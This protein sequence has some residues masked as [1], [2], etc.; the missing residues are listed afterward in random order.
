M[1]G[2]S[3]VGTPAVTKLLDNA[4]ASP[5]F[6]TPALMEPTASLKDGG[7][8]ASAPEQGC[9]LSSAPAGACAASAQLRV[10]RFMGV[11]RVSG[12]VQAATLYGHSAHASAPAFAASPR[13]QQLRQGWDGALMLPSSSC[14]AC[15][16]KRLGGRAGQAW[17]GMVGP[18]RK[19]LGP[20]LGAG[21][22]QE[23]GWDVPM[24]HTTPPPLDRGTGTWAAGAWGQQWICPRVQKV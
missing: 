9:L 13:L 12:S 17:P 19:E 11:G 10:T 5:G 8:S 2:D 1:E 3:Q 15:L 23:C 6:K 18:N 7:S 22:G 20:Q 4:L 14:L 24:P 21:V 16:R